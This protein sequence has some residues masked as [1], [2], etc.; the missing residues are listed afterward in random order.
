[1]RIH[2]DA[3]CKC[4]LEGGPSREIDDIFT[5]HFCSTCRDAFFCE[6]GVVQQFSSSN[7]VNYS[8]ADC[9]TPLSKKSIGEIAMEKAR[10]LM[11][12]KKLSHSGKFRPSLI[13]KKSVR[14]IE[15]LS[16]LYET[17]TTSAFHRSLISEIS[18]I[19]GI[20][21]QVIS[22]FA[23]DFGIS[24]NVISSLSGDT[25]AILVTL[26]SVSTK[27][28]EI[29]HSILIGRDPTEGGLS[30]RF[31]VFAS[32]IADVVFIQPAGSVIESGPYDLIAYDNQGMRIWVFCVE[33]T[34]DSM[35]IEKIVAPM[36]NQDLDVFTGV[37][38]IYLVAQGFS[39]V[40]KQLL[41]RYKGIVVTENTG[42]SRTI[43]FELWQ[44]KAISDKPE[45]IFEN[46]RL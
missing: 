34:I 25:E 1:M 27:F 45:I 18:R 15:T 5:A 39:W 44:E 36:L 23:R 4:Q 35:D 40:A 11:D 30:L 28:I 7:K 26:S 19:S 43:P 17:K 8:C 33:S 29:L 42:K 38:K 16:M 9:G 46:I 12:N 21:P 10:F 37:S 32:N 13:P 41:T 20:T 6:L 14:S 31:S 24:E 22:N 3:N 2:C